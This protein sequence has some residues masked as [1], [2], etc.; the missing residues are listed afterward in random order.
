MTPMPRRTGPHE[1]RRNVPNHSAQNTDRLR[2]HPS[3]DGGAARE[4]Q[5]RI[6]RSKLREGHEFAGEGL[7]D[8]RGQRVRALSLEG[9][10]TAEP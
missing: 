2:R 8:P 7:E 9:V 5:Q 1:G 4:V 10:G 6:V 3:D